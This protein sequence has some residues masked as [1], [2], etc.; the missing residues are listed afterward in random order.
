MEMFHRCFVFQNVLD[1]D[2]AKKSALFGDE[3]DSRAGRGLALVE[4]DG[5]LPS[6]PTP[7]SGTF[8][9]RSLTGAEARLIVE[10]TRDLS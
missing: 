1:R 2:Q 7:F 5:V 10:S 4:N 6:K 9:S 3:N 8:A